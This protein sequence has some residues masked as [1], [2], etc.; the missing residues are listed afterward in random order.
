[1][2]SVSLLAMFVVVLVIVFVAQWWSLRGK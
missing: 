1:M 2:V